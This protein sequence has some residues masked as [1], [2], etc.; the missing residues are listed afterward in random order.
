MFLT[1]FLTIFMIYLFKNK[2]YLFNNA[3]KLTIYFILLSLLFLIIPMFFDWYIDNS[4]LFANLEAYRLNVETLKYRLLGTFIFWTESS[5][6]NYGLPFGL[7]SVV[8][9]NLDGWAIPPDN[10]FMQ[11]LYEGGIINFILFCLFLVYALK[12]KTYKA[13]PEIL[14]FIFLT[15]FFTFNFLD[16]IKIRYETSFFWI[17]LGFLNH[18][19]EIPTANSIKKAINV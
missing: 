4:E 7:R 14:I 9:A 15:I 3:R 13:K 6:D 16:F 11:V 10:T 5:L 18:K 8:Y 12:N 2:Y 1:M 19:E 17:L